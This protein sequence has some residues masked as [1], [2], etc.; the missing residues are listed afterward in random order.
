MLLA[1]AFIMPAE[2]SFRSIHSVPLLQWMKEQPPGLTWWLW[3][4]L[5]LLCLLAANTLFCSVDSLIKKRRVTQWLLL[6]S[7]QLIHAG[8]LLML[9]AHLLSAMGSFKTFEVAGEGT[10]L[11]FS[12]TEELHVRAITISVDHLGYVTDWAVEVEY[13]NNGR[14]VKKDRVLPNGPSFQGGIGVYVRDLRAFPEKIVLL[15]LSREPGA[16]WAFIGGIL[17]MI[18]TITLLILK[19]R[20]ESGE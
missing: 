13:L 18:G 15:E 12:D 11:G 19:M 5:A 9:L 20:R 1:G 8:F 6:I 14:I 3:S 2:E 10:L 7:P 17:F 4:S 16:F